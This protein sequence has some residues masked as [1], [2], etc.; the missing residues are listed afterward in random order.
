MD[1][2]ILAAIIGGIFTVTGSLVTFVFTRVS[3]SHLFLAAKNIHHHALDG[4]WKGTFDQEG[5]VQNVPI[6]MP[7]DITFK[8]T[9]RMVRGE[10]SI[11]G[12]FK[13]QTFNAPVLLLGRFVNE[14]FIKIDYDYRSI[15]GQFGVA[16]LELSPDGR[17]LEGHWTG[18]GPVSRK[19]VHGNAQLSKQGAFPH[20]PTFP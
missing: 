19:I 10:G 11:T 8:S 4:N 12:T 17:T 20:L 6:S 7:V 15:T 5:G 3:D 13:N 14:R 9:R 18:Y 1:T 16:L 2:T